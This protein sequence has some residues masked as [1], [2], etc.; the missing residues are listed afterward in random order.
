MKF[1][2]TQELALID[3]GLKSLLDNLS[4][5]S[6]KKRGSYKIKKQAWNKD[7]KIRIWTKEQ[8]KKFSETMKK[9]WTNKDKITAH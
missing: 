2:R 1:T 5:I 8:R 7:K 3:L 6:N 4:P 9:K